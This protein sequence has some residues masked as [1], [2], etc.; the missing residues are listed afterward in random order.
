[1]KRIALLVALGS[2]ALIACNGTTRLDHSADSSDQGGLAGAHPLNIGGEGSSLPMGLGGGFVAVGG[3]SGASADAGATDADAG[4]GEVAAPLGP[5]SWDMYGTLSPADPSAAPNI[6]AGGGANIGSIYCPDVRFALTVDGTRMTLGADGA[7]SA[8]PVQ[9]PGTHYIAESVHLPP[10]ASCRVSELIAKELDLRGIDSDG[11]GIADVLKGT[12]TLDVYAPPPSGSDVGQHT[13]FIVDLAGSLDLSSPHFLVPSDTVD[14][15]DP[16]QIA[17]SEPLDSASRV[18]LKGT[19]V[20]PLSAVTSSADY[21]PNGAIQFGTKQILP[22]GGT[23]HVGGDVHDLIGN[24]LAGD[25]TLKTDADPGVLTQDGFESAFVQS[26]AD[27]V[28]SMGDIAAINGSYS[29]WI[30]PRD[31]TTYHLQRAGSESKLR[32]SARVFGGAGQTNL[33][34]YE[35]IRV[36]VVGGSKVTQVSVGQ[37]ALTTSDSGVA[38]LPLVSQVLSYE[39]TLDD[40]GTDVLVRIGY[41]P[42]T[43]LSA[44]PPVS[45]TC[46]SDSGWMIDDLRLE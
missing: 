34:P 21:A 32:F 30:A 18:E 41:V 31:Y 36:A 7:I 39:V 29:S 5:A 25:V 35:D 16:L 38:Q 23:W 3:A 12:A 26:D 11:D 14:P 28:S 9:L 27:R 15:L 44:P 24:A 43:P 33:N 40:P 45:P 37:T 8:V 1:M 4:S 13:K 42:C 19:S 20:I 22:L 6:G 46:P 10:T 17:A 2:N